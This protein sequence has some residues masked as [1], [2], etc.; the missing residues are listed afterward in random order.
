MTS[1]DIQKDVLYA[2]WL[3]HHEVVRQG[4]TLDASG[5]HVVLQHALHN[6]LVAAS[7]LSQLTSSPRAL[8][9]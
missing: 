8:R 5:I 9:G 2:T 1:E 6:D 3:S 4:Y 7:Q